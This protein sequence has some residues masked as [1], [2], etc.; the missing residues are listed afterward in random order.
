MLV[1]KPQHIQYL[2]D[3]D[4]RSHFFEFVAAAVLVGVNS[5]KRAYA[6]RPFDYRLVR[7]NTQVVDARNGVAAYYVVDPGGAGLDVLAD[8]ELL[9]GVDRLGAAA[10][11]PGEHL[12]AVRQ[13]GQGEFRRAGDGNAAA[14]RSAD[15]EPPAADRAAVAV[16]GA[17]NHG[18]TGFAAEV[19]GFSGDIHRFR[20]G[21]PLLDAVQRGAVLSEVQHFDEHNSVK[22][23]LVP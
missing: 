8:G 9:V 16:V 4:I 20:P 21:V 22:H 6:D 13:S 5:I 3:R 11:L 19:L 12:H 1:G 17:G 15:I 14:D 7:D 10:N 18:D 23:Y 2:A